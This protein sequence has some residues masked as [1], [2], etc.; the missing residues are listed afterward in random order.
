MTI[1]DSE[2]AMMSRMSGSCSPAS[3]MAAPITII[4]QM[5]TKYIRLSVILSLSRKNETL[6][7]SAVSLLT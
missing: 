2:D 7:V 5:T 4:P 1:P 3:R 6:S